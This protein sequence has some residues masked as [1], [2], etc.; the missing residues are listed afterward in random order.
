MEL[1]EVFNQLLLL[2]DLRVLIPIIPVVLRLNMMGRVYCK[3]N[4]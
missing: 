2:G 4:L 1:L 3:I